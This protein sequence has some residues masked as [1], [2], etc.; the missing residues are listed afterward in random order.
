MITKPQLKTVHVLWREIDAGRG[1]ERD[2]R[3]A[4]IEEISRIIRR[5][6]SW[7]RGIEAERV[8]S[9]PDIRTGP[10]FR[11]QRRV[12]RRPG[13]LKSAFP[14]SLLTHPLTARPSFPALFGFMFPLFLPK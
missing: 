13:G 5:K 3:T 6:R 10:N 2:S 14:H 8:H 11:G 12:E 9:S 4:R 7:K 1:D